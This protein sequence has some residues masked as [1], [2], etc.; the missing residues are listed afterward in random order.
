M[1]RARDLV[2]AHP[3]VVESHWFLGEAAPRVFYTMFGVP[4]IGS[5]ATPVRS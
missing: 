2:N 4:G 3:E 5:R 1:E